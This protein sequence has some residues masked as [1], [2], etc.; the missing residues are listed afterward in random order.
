MATS[1]DELKSEVRDFTDYG[2]SRIS[3][4]E[5]VTILKRAKRNIRAEK[6]IS[7]ASFDW[8]STVQREDA[9]FW[10]TCVFAKVHVGELDAADVEFGELV[11]QPL[12]GEDAEATIWMREAAS[13][14]RNFETGSDYDFGFGISS[15]AREDRVYGDDGTNTGT[16]L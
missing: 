13:A 7:D 5:L 2:T 4:P 16:E 15:P 6:G 14:V 1:D 12:T 10:S 11:G 8:Y 9:L 3:D